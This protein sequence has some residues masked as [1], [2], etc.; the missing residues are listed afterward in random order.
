MERKLTTCYTRYGRMKGPPLGGLIEMRINF[1]FAFIALIDEGELEESLD[2]SAFVFGTH[3][4]KVEVD[5]PFVFG[6]KEGITGN[7][8]DTLR[9]GVTLNREVV[10]TVDSLGCQRLVVHYVCVFIV[11]MW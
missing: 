6:D 2:V 4:I 1:V 5:G 9:E 7:V 10:R 8:L 11:S 3:A